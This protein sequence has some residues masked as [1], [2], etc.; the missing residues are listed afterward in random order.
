MAGRLSEAAQRVALY[1]RVSTASGQDVEL[2]LEELRRLA[3]LRGWTV[4][5]VHADEGVSGAA[6]DRPGL[7]KLMAQAQ[8][9]SFDL[10]LV[11]KLDRLGR[12]LRHL[13]S[14]LDDLQ[15]WGVGFASARDPGLDTTT[16]SG[17]LLLQVLGAF[18]EF[19]RELIRERVIAG[20]R[21]AQASGRH[22][23]RPRIE[24]D[25]RPALA[26]IREGHGLKST[27]GALGVGRSTLRRRLREAGEWPRVAPGR[28]PTSQRS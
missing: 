26:M 23:G 27:A 17:R 6:S 24:V 10:V 28:G 18:A 9:R 16:P 8:A 12:S 19:E 25:L 13:L 2:Q 21:R 4:T 15:A 14:V 5:A 3:Q 20:V 1:A 22:C 11:W 7:N